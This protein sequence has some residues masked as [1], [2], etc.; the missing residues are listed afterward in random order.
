MGGATGTGLGWAGAG[1]GGDAFSFRAFLPGDYQAKPR[2]QFPGYVTGMGE[3]T[4]GHS[5]SLLG[6]G[7]LVGALLLLEHLRP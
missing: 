3:R 1:A 6:L 4:G 7:L 2:P 5:V